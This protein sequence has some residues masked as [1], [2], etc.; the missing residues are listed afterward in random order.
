MAI[1]GPH[2]G[3]TCAI[4]VTFSRIEPLARP[5]SVCRSPQRHL[6]DPALVHGV[7][8]TTLANKFRLSHD[9][10]TRHAANHLTPTQRAA[11]LTASEPSKIDLERLRRSESEGLLASLLAQR[12][13]LQQVIEMA[14]AAGDLAAATSAE[15]AMTQ[16][17]SLTARLLGQL[18]SISEHRSTHLLTSADYVRMRHA[19]TAALRPFPEAARAVAQALARLETDAAGEILERAGK[20][21]PVLIEHQPAAVAPAPE[22][23]APPY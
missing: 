16:S 2:E 21:S 11:L 17:L 7:A 6:I 1:Y 18:V 12:A 10:I 20:A 3:H 4:C 13:R 19:L 22:I 15:K 5:C 14:V 23:P 8:A 9:A